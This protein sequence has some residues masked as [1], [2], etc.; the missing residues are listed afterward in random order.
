MR[1]IRESQQAFEGDRENKGVTVAFVARKPAC[2]I[3]AKGE[4]ICSSWVLSPGTHL[5]VLLGVHRR[6][7]A[8]KVSC[9]PFTLTLVTCPAGWQ[10]TQT[11]HSAVFKFSL[12]GHVVMSNEDSDAVE[13]A[14]G[15]L[16]LIPGET[17]DVSL[18][19]N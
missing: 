7:K 17:R 4:K 19:D 6:I 1:T 10:L 14:L 12:K 15:K 13:L 2:Y 8:A 18:Q 5:S 16:P 9:H 11:I 3:E